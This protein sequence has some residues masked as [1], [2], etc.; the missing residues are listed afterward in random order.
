MHPPLLAIGDGALGFW[1]ALDELYPK[2]RHQRCWVHKA[3]NVLNYA[4]KAMQPRMKN[5]LHESG[6]PR[7]VPRLRAFDQFVT[8]L[9][10]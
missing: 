4:P 3:V 1:A 7:R 6:W 5:A 9:R 8:E 2:T 10:R